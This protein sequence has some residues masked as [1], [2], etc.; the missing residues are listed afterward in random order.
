MYHGHTTHH[1]S[2]MQA[3]SFCWSAKNEPPLKNC[4]KRVL[5]LLTLTTLYYICNITYPDH[6]KAEQ[7]RLRNNEKT[8][9]DGQNTEPKE[10]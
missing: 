3:V 2:S 9:S 10:D 6:N 8:T 1:H 5:H 4:H 7:D